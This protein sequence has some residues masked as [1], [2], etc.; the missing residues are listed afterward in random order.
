VVVVEVARFLLGGLGIR[1]SEKAREREICFFFFS[2]LRVFLG[3][4]GK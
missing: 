2:S 4:R 3:E 1:G